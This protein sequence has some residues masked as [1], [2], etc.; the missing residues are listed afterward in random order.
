M[1]S[2]I[3]EWGKFVRL[4]FHHIFGSGNLVSSRIREEACG[5]TI[6]SCGVKPPEMATVW[7]Q[8]LMQ[9]WVLLHLVP[10][11]PLSLDLFL[12]YRSLLQSL[13]CWFLFMFPTSKY[14]RSWDCSPWASSLLR[15]RNT[16]SLM[17]SFAGV[18]YYLWAHVP[19]FPSPAWTTF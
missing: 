16:P 14:Q 1:A 15:M 5:S 13:L 3:G 9:T 10:R 17:L 6:I 4:I 12:L 2:H 18:K 7:K 19:R 8:L 11:V